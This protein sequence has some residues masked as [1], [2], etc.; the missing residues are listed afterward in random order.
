MTDPFMTPAENET[1]DADPVLAEWV[2]EAADRISQGERVSA[3][4]HDAGNVLR[5]ETLRRFL[6][7]MEKMSR[8]R[9]RLWPADSPRLDP[10]G[11]GFESERILGDFRTVRII[12]RGGMGVVYEAVQLSLNRRVALK[13]LPAVSADDPW[14]LKRFQ[15]EA[16]ATA[17][18][19]HPHIVPVFMVGYESRVHYFA[20]QL[21]KGRTLAEV[22]ASYRQAGQDV[23][24]TRG[25]QIPPRVVADLGRQAAEALHYAHRQGVIHRDVKPANLL[26]EDSGWLWVADFGLARVCGQLDSTAS[27]AIRGTPR[28]MSPEQA[29]GERTLIDHRTDVYSLGVTLYELLTLRPAY[30]GDDRLE[31]L[32]QIA[33]VE[34]RAPRR[35]DPSIPPDLETI[36]LKA[37]AKDPAERYETA[38]D[39]ADDL[40]RFLTHRSILARPPGVLQRAVRWARLHKS[41]VAMAAV[42]ML[43]AATGLCAVAAWRE[44]ELRKHNRELRS[45]LAIVERNELTNR[46]LWYGSQVRLAQ[47]ELGTGQVEFA[48]EVLERLRPGPGERDLRG[49]EWY[50]LRR[51][52]HRDVSV[53]F[54]HESPIS[55][56]ALSPDARTLVTGDQAGDVLVWDLADWRL[57]AGARGRRDPIRLLAFAPDGRTVASLSGPAARPHQITLWDLETAHETAR[58][59]GISGGVDAFAFSRDGRTLAAWERG[60][61]AGGSSRQVSFWDVS[62][63]AGHVS[64]GSPPVVCTFVAV[65]P[66]HSLLATSGPSGEVTLRDASTGRAARTLSGCCSNIAAITFTP[67]GRS[68]LV[69]DEG[70]VSFFD[71]ASGREQGRIASAPGAGPGLSFDVLGFLGLPLRH[72]RDAWLTDP[73]SGLRPTPLEGVSHGNSKFV[74]SPDGRRLAAGGEFLRPI[75]WDTLSGK[76]CAGFPMRM[77]N[78]GSLVFT[79]G[80]ESLIFGSEDARVRAWHIEERPEP[81]SRLSGHQAEVWSLAYTPD[82]STLIS[83]ADDHTIKLWDPSGGALRGTLEGHGSLVAFLAVSPDGTTLASAGFDRTVRLWDLP[84]GRP[85]TVLHGHTDRVRGVAFSPDGR[86]V[87][88]CGSDGTVRLWDADEERELW[89]VRSHTDSVH[90][91][92][93]NPDGTH[94]VSAGN[95]RT[96]R[97]WDLAAGKVSRTICCPK[98]NMALAFS[99]DGSLLASGDDWGNV[100]IWDVPRWSK[101]TGIKGSDAEIWGLAFS[102][103]GRTLAAAC[104]DARVRLWDP[105]TGQLTLVLDGHIQRVNAVAFS[106]DGATLAS[107]SHDGAVKLWH[108]EHR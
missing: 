96:L 35:I 72:G 75:L 40:G 54:G 21:I 83:A 87:A 30:E 60:S 63:G 16:Q 52:A 13:A 89:A 49:F 59:P 65:S 6:P 91:L 64:P 26:V 42:L 51:L 67:D 4:G 80:G 22:I 77:G 57:R 10:S 99:R 74:F 90:A 5:V 34:P 43:A 82:G 38:G 18:L 101:R 84:S 94:L 41:A 97:V 27:D 88:S 29:L 107:A 36:V 106:P 58:I 47:Q 20:M 61:D 12:G 31:L 7:A 76:K 98:S 100:T 17:C 85:Q 69:L 39:L 55:A 86:Q 28:Y 33:R 8:L 95:D 9:D 25:G 56:L 3:D 46:R 53:L 103:D 78:V 11:A 71:V 108:A 62:P 92:V 45:T 68:V 105:L 79:P 48:Q 44:A 14:L 102:P 32:R 24:R 93:F 15:V 81:L 73:R 50:Y 66:D 1:V 19:H 37:M 104:G 2:A 23:D 70:G